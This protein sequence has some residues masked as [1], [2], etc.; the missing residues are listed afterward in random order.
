MKK[1]K[2]SIG[3]EDIAFIDEGRGDVVLFIHGNMSSSAHF[4]PLIERIKHKYR[5]VA[6]DLRGFG[7]STYNN[8][9]DTLDELAEDVNL[10]TERMGI[11]S[12]YLVGWSNGGGVSLKLCAKYP[13][14]IKKFFDIEGAGLKG[15]PLYQKE[16]Y[17]STGKPYACKE[18]M[19]NDLPPQYQRTF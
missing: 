12:Y 15:Y 13:E 18:D 2:I 3:H 7:D 17:Q 16:N 11:K 5:C 8:R 9:F 19:A 4:L 6:V 10:F 1:Y 14:K